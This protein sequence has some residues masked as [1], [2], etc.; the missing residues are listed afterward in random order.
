MFVS[1]PPLRDLLA[2]VGLGR[3]S[4]GLIVLVG[5]AGVACAGAVALTTQVDTGP[6]LVVDRAAEASATIPGIVSQEPSGE[7]TLVV[8]VAGAVL[9]PGLVW[10][11]GGSRVGDA[12]EAAGGNLGSAALDALNLARLLSDGEQVY[13]PSLDEVAAGTA[14]SLT[15]GS[16]GPPESSAHVDLNSADVTALDTLPGVGPS[17]AAKIVADREANGPF[18]SVD[19]LQRVA[20]I[21][22]KRIEE[23]RE[24]VE[25]R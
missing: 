14:S 15:G 1:V 16:I 4:I 18:T 11:P 2:R 24:L 25:V 17:T 8:H 5:A 22:P 9:R 6:S 12:I 21:G 10:M 20:G 19:D 3:V 23:I 13:V 7:T